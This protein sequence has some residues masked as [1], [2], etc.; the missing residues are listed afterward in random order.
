MESNKGRDSRGKIREYGLFDTN[1]RVVDGHTRPC[2]ECGVVDWQ[3][4]DTRGEIICNSC[5]LVVERMLL[6]PA[7]SGLTEIKQKTAQG[8]VSH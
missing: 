2:D 8:L 5:G 1:R 7:L 6:I 4:D 3:M